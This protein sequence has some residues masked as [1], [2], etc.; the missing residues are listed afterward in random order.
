MAK[1]KDDLTRLKGNKVSV[2]FN[3]LERILKQ[4]GWELQSTS[5]SH[6]VYAKADRL[7][8]MIVK[9]HGKHKYCHPMDVN[10]VIAELE[11]EEESKEAN[12]EQSDES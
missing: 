5:G 1:K 7:P 12:D 3:G 8:V 6:H 4:H 9:P 2:R 11:F 10:K